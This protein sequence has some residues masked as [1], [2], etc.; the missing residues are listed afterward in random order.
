MKALFLVALLFATPALAAEP[1]PYPA[2]PEN[3]AISAV[4]QQRNAALVKGADAEASIA[5]MQAQE[6]RIARYW[7]DFVKGLKAPE[8]PSTPVAPEPASEK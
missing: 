4:Q 3:A 2:P 8:S 6:A 7:E 5:Y 1:A